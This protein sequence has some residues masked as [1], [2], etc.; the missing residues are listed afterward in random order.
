MQEQIYIRDSIIEKARALLKQNQIKF[1]Q[2]E[3]YDVEV[4]Y[5]ML[6]NAETSFPLLKV[7]RHTKL[8]KRR[9][10]H[11]LNTFKLPEIPKQVK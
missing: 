10:S 4:I 11:I 9:D 3:N 1:I 7:S 2:D 5:D 8:L 6:E